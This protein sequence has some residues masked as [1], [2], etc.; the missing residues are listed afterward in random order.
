MATRLIGRDAELS[1]LTA[2]LDRTAHSRSRIVMLSGEAGIGKSR[3]AAEIVA[4]ARDRGFTTLEGRA[5]PLHATL[6][7]API[8]EALRSHLSEDSRPSADS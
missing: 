4:V 2:A 6:A 8:V 5:H 7:Y 1:S 3:L